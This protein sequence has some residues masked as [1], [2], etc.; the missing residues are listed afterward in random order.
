MGS[1][2]PLKMLGGLAGGAS[3]PRAPEPVK[4]PTED[5]SAAD[6]AKAAEEEK[7]RRKTQKG[8]AAT[9]LS[10]G[11]MGDDSSTGSSGLATKK[12]LGG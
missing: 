7:Q 6:I 1:F 10:R 9:I 12:L 11:V 8:R 4:I 5:N 3:K 2:S